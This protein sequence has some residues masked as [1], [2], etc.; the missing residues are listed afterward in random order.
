MT[1]ERMDARW[2][3]LLG[4]VGYL[5]IVVWGHFATELPWY[6]MIGVSIYWVWPYAF[7]VGVI[8]TFWGLING[9]FSGEV[10]DRREQL[11]T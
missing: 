6:G 4:V 10:V 5:G 9:E 11:G 8:W 2:G 7:S 3:I 1:W